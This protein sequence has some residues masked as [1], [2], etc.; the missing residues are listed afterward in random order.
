[1]IKPIGVRALEGFR[2]WIKFS[3]GVKGEVD[4]THLSGKGVFKAWSDRGFFEN[5]RITPYEAVTWGVDI[6]LCPDAFY[7]EISGRT[8][9]E[10]ERESAQVSTHA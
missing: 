3:D 10:A 8:V 2:I 1:M 9:E 5:V 4:L 7:L 6:D